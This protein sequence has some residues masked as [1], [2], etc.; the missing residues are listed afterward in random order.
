MPYQSR[1]QPTEGQ[2]E[3]MLKMRDQGIPRTRIAEALG[4]SPRTV[5][6][7]FDEYDKEVMPKGCSRYGKKA[8]RESCGI[9][10]DLTCLVDVLKGDSVTDG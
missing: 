6:R 9:Y 10:F 7:W 5:F 1:M 4:R 8:A 2:L 3:Q